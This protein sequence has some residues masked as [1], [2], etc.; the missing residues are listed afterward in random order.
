LLKARI[1]LAR[2]KGQDA[3]VVAELRNLIAAHQRRVKSMEDLVEAGITNHIRVDL[4]RVDLLN[5]EIK[6]LKQAK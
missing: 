3:V 1:R 6:L 5:A 4:A 2:A